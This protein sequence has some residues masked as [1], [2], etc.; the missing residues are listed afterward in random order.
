M[1][2]RNTD[3]DLNYSAVAVWIFTSE[4]AHR[5]KR[6]MK[7]A[8]AVKDSAKIPESPITDNSFSYT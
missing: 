5:E 8:N 1:A 3:P 4:Q 7:V 2:R 6:L